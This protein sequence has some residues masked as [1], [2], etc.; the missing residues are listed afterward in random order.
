MIYKNPSNRKVECNSLTFLFMCKN[1]FQPYLALTPNDLVVEGL[2][3]SSL[4]YA[5]QYLY[6]L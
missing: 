3:K 2:P 6:C 5:K 4:F 1:F